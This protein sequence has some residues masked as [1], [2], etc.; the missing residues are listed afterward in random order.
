MEKLFKLVIKD[1]DPHSG[2]V[3]DFKKPSII[4]VL[5]EKTA[6]Y[7][8]YYWDNQMYYHRTRCVALT[9]YTLDDYLSDDNG[10]DCFDEEIFNSKLSVREYFGKSREI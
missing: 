4:Y 8:K 6:K 3:Q 5:G 1:I 9:E 10:G 7:E 2:E